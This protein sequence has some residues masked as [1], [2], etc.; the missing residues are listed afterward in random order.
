MTDSRTGF[1]RLAR[2]YQALELLAFGRDLERA[3]FEFLGRLAQSRDVLLLGEGDGR[4]ARRLALLA[5]RA[6]ILCVDSSPG[7]IARAS[8]R[9]AGPQGARV[10]FLCAD[11]L[12]F[13]PGSRTF[14]AV[15][16][17]FFLD[18]FDEPGVASIAERVG[19]ALRP[20]ALWLFADFALPPRG[21]PRLRARA[22]LAFLYLFFRWG[23]GL[24][25]STLPRSE[26]IL[27][28]AGWRLAA[29]REFQGGMVRSAVFHLPTRATGAQAASTSPG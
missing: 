7:M 19:P 1:G 23:A 2:C 6:R 29:C 22:W 4:C 13:D 15:A 28:R 16:T 10:T 12:S 5:P 25:V 26:E 21:L 14:D 17:L 9:T 3:R 27:G 11:A 18:C 24:R 8:R 20:G